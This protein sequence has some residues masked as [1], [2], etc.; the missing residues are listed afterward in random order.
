MNISIYQL[1]DGSRQ[2]KGLTVIIDVFRAFSFECYCFSMGAKS[3]IPIGNAEI[4]YK[5]KAENPQMILAGERH[6]VILPGFDVGNSPSQLCRLDV[7]GK[8]VLHTTSAGTQGIA[9]AHNATEIIGGSLV[10][11]RATA[12]YIK[13]SGAS[14]VSLV[15]MGLDAKYPTQ[16]DTLCAEY[17][18]SLIEEK[19][20]DM[21]PLVENL[22]YTSG[23]KFFDSDQ[24]DVFP[25]EDFYMCTRLNIFDFVLK[26][27]KNPDGLGKMTRIAI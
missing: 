9:N 17:I 3:I 19:P 6:G 24:A 5:M 4:A 8:T 25:T 12:E 26:L 27:Q 1:L 14:E 13:K 15:C 10:N 22:K 7:S 20:L 11:A 16:E 18:K 21:P 2:A 23:A